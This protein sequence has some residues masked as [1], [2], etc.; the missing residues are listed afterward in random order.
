MAQAPMFNQLGTEQVA[1]QFKPKE[2]FIT[3]LY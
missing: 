3:I 1:V 2:E